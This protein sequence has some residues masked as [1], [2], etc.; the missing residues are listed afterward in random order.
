MAENT[1]DDM[2]FMWCYNLPY[3]LHTVQKLHLTHGLPLKVTLLRSQ[4][5]YCK[6]KSK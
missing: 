3:K 2:K 5:F 6:I 4:S 1:L